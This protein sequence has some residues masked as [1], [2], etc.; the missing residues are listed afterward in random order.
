MAGAERNSS[1]VFL[2][3][4]TQMQQV[5]HV[6]V[7]GSVTEPSCEAVLLCDWS[8]RCVLVIVSSHLK[9]SVHRCREVDRRRLGPP[10]ERHRHRLQTRSAIFSAARLHTFEHLHASRSATTRSGPSQ[11]MG[12]IY[13]KS[14]SSSASVK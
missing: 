2:D 9:L 4:V 7:T 5:L 10:E 1:S 13:L 8:A 6:K 14:S 11:K 3:S 12:L